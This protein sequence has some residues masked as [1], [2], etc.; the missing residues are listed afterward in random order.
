MNPPDFRSALASTAFRRLCLAH[1]VATVGQLVLT[2]AVGVHVLVETRSGVWVSVTVALAFAPYALCSA[3]AGVLADRRSRSAVLAGAAWVRA[4]L[5]LGLVLGTAMGWPVAVMVGVTALVAVAATPSFPSLAAATPECVPDRD[6]PPA[7]ALVTCV[8]NV[9]WI[10]GPGVFGLLVLAGA[11]TEV[12][13]LIAAVLFVVAGTVAAPVR[14]HR[15]VRPQPTSWLGD[16][17]TGVATTTYNV[18]A[19][20]AG[21]YPFVCTVHA[22][23]TGTLTA[24]S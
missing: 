9:T 19:L 6:L 23:M 11:G 20:K 3:L 4:A 7:N 13:V 24:G 15:P 22:N 12:T 16:L 1:G 5:A 2:L 18:P 8:E 17:V 14:L 21:T 10:G